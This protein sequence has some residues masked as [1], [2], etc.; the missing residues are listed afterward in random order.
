MIRK[1][2][3]SPFLTLLLISAA[4]MPIT[5]VVA[6]DK[7]W[8]A[9]RA[10]VCQFVSNES[11]CNAVRPSHAQY[12]DA[13]IGSIERKDGI[14]I[15]VMGGKRIEFRNIHENGLDPQEAYSFVGFLP[16]HQYFVVVGAFN[17]GEDFGYFF[18]S[19]LTGNTHRLFGEPILSPDGKYV[20]VIPRQHGGI[21][22]V[23][24]L[25]TIDAQG[26]N[27][28]TKLEFGNCLSPHPPNCPDISSALWISNAEVVAFSLE[29]TRPPKREVGHFLVRIRREDNGW[30]VKRIGR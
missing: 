15:T 18:V 23:G 2:R 21:S 20:F 30:S 16:Q 25:Y 17:Y 6:L 22:T 28:L 14:S 9:Y 5:S 11:T 1:I 3:L 26:L 8:E 10:T 29:Y 24:E 12:S 19:N 13:P 7:Q 27:L 4:L